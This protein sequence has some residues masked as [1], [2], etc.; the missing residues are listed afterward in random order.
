MSD[1]HPPDDIEE[2]AVTEDAVIRLVGAR[3]LRNLDPANPAHTAFLDWLAADLRERETDEERGETRVHA[4]VWADRMVA[5]QLGARL[6]LTLAEG[7]SPISY[8][9]RPAPLALRVEEGVAGGRIASI[10]FRAAAGVGREI[11][12]EPCSETIERPDGVGTGRYLALRV[13]GE[14]MSPLMHDGDTV[15]VKLGPVVTSDTVIVARRPD[16]GYVVKRV[17]RIGLESI[18]LTSVNPDF[19][20]VEL[21]RDDQLILGTVVMRWCAHAAAP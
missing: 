8:A 13:A 19:P 9:C 1:R 14:S 5:R 10:D 12:E 11:W 16:D 6:R 20:P 7:A 4:R 3:A 18:E 15:L 21:P 2:S 17:G